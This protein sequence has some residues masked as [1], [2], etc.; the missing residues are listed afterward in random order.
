MTDDLKAITCVPSPLSN[1][2][3][4]GGLIAEGSV[5]CNNDR[6]MERKVDVAVFSNLSMQMDKKDYCVSADDF[7]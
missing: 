5:K 1:K 2:S 6:T 7:R 3:N 4:N